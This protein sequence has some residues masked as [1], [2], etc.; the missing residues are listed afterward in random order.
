MEGAL[1]LADAVAREA[2]LF[3]AIGFLIGGFDDL[4]IDLWMTRHAA[5][6]AT[7]YRRHPRATLQGFPESAHRFAVFVPAWDEG[8]AAARMLRTLLAR[9]DCPGLVVFAGCYPNDQVTIDAVVDVAGEDDRLALVII[10]RPSP[11]TKAD[12]LNA[13]WHALE[14]HE[15]TS[16]QRFYAVVLHDAEDVVATGELRLFAHL[17][18]APRSCNCRCCL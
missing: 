4:L 9:L 10:P 3:A 14:R 16:G 5:R 7:I 15:S 6:S 2:L 1:W 17:L 8:A 12:N 18:G 13:M 11:T